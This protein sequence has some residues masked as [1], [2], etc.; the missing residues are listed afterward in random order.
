[1]FLR[2]SFSLFCLFTSIRLR[3][4]SNNFLAAREIESPSTVL[5]IA[6]LCFCIAS[7]CAFVRFNVKSFLAPK[8]FLYLFFRIKTSTLLLAGS[9]G[10][11]AVSKGLVSAYPVAE[12][13]EGENLNLSIKYLT[14]EHALALKVPSL[15]GKLNLL[16]HSCQYGLRQ[17]C[18]VI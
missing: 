6:A 13:N 11:I 8:C 12:N 1:M 2:E 15:M 7:C 14:T 17:S 16:L 10:E 4:S 18:C 9:L 5:I 3:F